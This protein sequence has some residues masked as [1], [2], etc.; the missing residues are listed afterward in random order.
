MQSPGLFPLIICFHICHDFAAQVKQEEE[1]D[2][3]AYDASPEPVKS[4]SGSD[5]SSE[6]ESD[7]DIVGQDIP[8]PPTQNGKVIAQNVEPPQPSSQPI[9][10]ED[11]PTPAPAAAPSPV[12]NSPLAPKNLL[13]NLTAE[14][15]EEGERIHTSHDTN[16]HNPILYNFITSIHVYEKEKENSYVQSVAWIFGCRMTLVFVFLI[17]PGSGCTDVQKRKQEAQVRLAQYEPHYTWNSF[18]NIHLWKLR[19]GSTQSK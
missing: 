6:S 14:A 19:P 15:G 1:E 12:P 3:D 10:A 7:Q 2:D 13:G 5:S 18:A 4:A 9:L 11:T 8:P 16:P 17:L